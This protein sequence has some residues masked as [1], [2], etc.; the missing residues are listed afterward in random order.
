MIEAK[1]DRYR[2]TTPR[3][4]TELNASTFKKMIMKSVDQLREHQNAVNSI[5]V[6]PVKDGDTGTNMLNTMIGVK[7]S[8]EELSD[9]SF[10]TISKELINA[11]ILSARGNSGTILAEYFRGFMLEIKDIQVLTGSHLVRA[12]KNG[13]NNA[14]QALEQPT[15]GTI[16]DVFS[17]AAKG[18][19]LAHKETNDICK[20]LDEALKYALIAL[21]NTQFILPQMQRS[22]VVDAGGAGFLFI[23]DGLR[24]GVSDRNSKISEEFISKPMIVQD[25]E[26]SFQYCVEAVLKDIG[27]PIEELRKKIENLGNSFHL[28]GDIDLLK[29]HIHTN[30]PNSIKE[31]CQDTGRIV[32]WKVDDIQE[33]QKEYLTNLQKSQEHADILHYNISRSVTKNRIAVV[34]DS[35]SDISEKWLKQYPIFIVKMPVILA[36]D[37]TDLA[38]RVTL[39]EFYNRM[40]TEENFVP[41]TSQPN[42]K[43]FI[44][45]YEKALDIADI[46]LCIPIS[47]SLSGSYRNAVQAK[48]KLDNENIFVID[49]YSASLGVSI[50]VH[51]VFELQKAG[52]DYLDI[53]TELYAIRGRMGQYFIANDT[54]YLFRGGRLTRSRY[55]LG[56]ILHIHPL[57]QLKDGYILDTGRRIHSTNPEKQ[58]I[59]LA[60]EIEKFITRREPLCIYIVHSNAEAKAL[61]L[62]EYLEKNNLSKGIIEIAEFGMVVGSHLGPGVLAIYYA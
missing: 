51:I 27:V 53:L 11:I 29:L 33:M 44:D 32:D 4:Y 38:E 54:K 13:S 47:S 2:P 57:L 45:A 60:R 42:V 9:N 24:A 6:F 22:Q 50:L 25:E 31:I 30:R 62:K 55:I 3:E 5:N 61:K 18:A 17:A 19:D 46:V 7:N 14:Q 1:I 56:H 49:S 28:M 21:K 34:T 40:A 58:V 52:K 23:L 16:L 12:L 43:Q 10:E 48:N 15:M 20:I 41:I 59:M 35:S 36:N 37:P 8:L 26:L 39:K